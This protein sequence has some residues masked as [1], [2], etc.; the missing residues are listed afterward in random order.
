MRTERSNLPEVEPLGSYSGLESVVIGGG[1]C[2]C[3]NINAC[4]L[5]LYASVNSFIARARFLTRMA[6][7]AILIIR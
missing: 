4:L 1:L 5:C 7:A 2:D 3:D 6:I